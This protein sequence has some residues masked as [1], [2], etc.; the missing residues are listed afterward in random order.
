[1]SFHMGNSASYRLYTQR[2][3][4]FFIGDPQAVPESAVNCIIRTNEAPDPLNA[5]RRST[6]H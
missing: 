6:N 4:N 1:M 5:L 2:F 3:L